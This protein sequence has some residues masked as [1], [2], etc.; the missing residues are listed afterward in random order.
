MSIKLVD[1][2]VMQEKYSV[3]ILAIWIIDYWI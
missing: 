2:Y 1:Y 3:Y